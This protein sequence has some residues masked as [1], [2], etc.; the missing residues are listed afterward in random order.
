V[1]TNEHHGVATRSFQPG[2]ASPGLLVTHPAGD[3]DAPTELIGG[4]GARRVD[5]DADDGAKPDKAA[6]ADSLGPRLGPAA[7]FATT[8]H[9]NLQTPARSWSHP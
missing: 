6:L 8:E 1:S 9:F 7:T 5:Q 2:L 4:G 3:S